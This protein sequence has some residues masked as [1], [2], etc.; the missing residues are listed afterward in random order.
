M[1]PITAAVLAA[2]TSGSAGYWLGR[3]I[4]DRA[5]PR[6]EEIAGVPAEELEA[7]ERKLR[8]VL[9][10][11]ER[12]SLPNPESGMPARVTTMQVR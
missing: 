9:F 2:I 4:H 5:V 6:L 8:R 10:D 12:Y 1:S 11:A 3:F 7:R